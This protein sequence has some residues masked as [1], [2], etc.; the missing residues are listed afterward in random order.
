MSKPR[1]PLSMRQ[2]T[3]IQFISRYS[4]VIVQLV[5]TMV[6]A[7]HLTPDEFGTVGIVTI[8]TNFFIMVSDLGLGSGIIQYQELTERDI[9]GLFR[10]SFWMSVLLAALFMALSLPATLLYKNELLIR[11]FIAAA[12]G[13]FFSVFNV[14]PNGVLLREK[15][16]M[17]VGI[18]LV[19]VNAL[20]G[21]VAILLALAGAGCYALVAQF[22]VSSALLFL[23]DT[24]ASGIRIRREPMLKPLR[25]IFSFSIFQFAHSVVTYFSRN[26]DNLMI[27]YFFGSAPL[28]YYDKA[29]KLSNYPLI[30]FSSVIESVL[31]PYLADLQ[32]DSDAIY[33]RFV[34]IARGVFAV[35]ILV[36]TCCMAA[37]EE[38]IALMFGD[39]WQAAVPLFRAISVSIMFQMVTTL[40]GAVF[41]SLGKTREMLYT[42]I[43]NTGIVFLAV[44]GG[45]IAKSLLLVAVLVSAAYCLNPLATF[46]ILVVKGFRKPIRPFVRTFLPQL[47]SAVLMLGIAFALYT[48]LKGIALPLGPLLPLALK[49]ALCAA[50]YALLLLL[51]GQWRCLSFLVS[52]TKKEA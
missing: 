38:I 27:G 33:Q 8:F 18:R 49:T 39:Q 50:V 31:H 5:I 20:S 1:T 46:G 32:H 22:S 16:F 37:S 30:G 19:V 6:L 12:P 40:T 17:A 15:R 25:T 11:L 36:S 23:W 10:L 44:S 52:K 51:T 29:Y 42:T 34:E 41:K 47:L 7:R 28:G 9:C 24:V 35:G 45:V 3:I 26:L 13:V 48:L 21:L 43:I 14:V 4:S 2:A